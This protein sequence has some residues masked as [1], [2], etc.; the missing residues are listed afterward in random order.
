VFNVKGL[1]SHLDEKF[2][3]REI[4]KMNM[5]RTACQPIFEADMSTLSEDLLIS[6][7][8]LI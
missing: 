5:F 7:L 4:D 1:F 6:I 2:D 3:G 8:E